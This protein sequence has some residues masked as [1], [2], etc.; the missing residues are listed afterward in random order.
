MNAGITVVPH[1]YGK[2]RI[3]HTE[4]DVV[5]ALNVIPEVRPA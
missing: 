3:T 2:D 4:A 1:K 5:N